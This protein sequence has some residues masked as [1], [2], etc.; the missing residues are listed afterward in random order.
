LQAEA[1]ALGEELARLETERARRR[2]ELVAA[3]RAASASRERL[4]QWLVARYEAG[5]LALLA[6]VFDASGWEEVAY[7][8]ELVARLGEYEAAVFRKARRTMSSHREALK[9]LRRTEA[10]IASREREL[11]RQAA[12]L[13]QAQAEHAALL[14][15]I[16][17][18]AAGVAASIT[19]LERYWFDTLHSLKRA[20]QVLHSLWTKGRLKPDRTAFTFGGLRLEI[21]D[22]SLERQM[23]A[24]GG[25]DMPGVAIRPEGISLRHSG[26]GYELRGRLVCADEGATV[27]FVPQ[28]LL[29]DGTPVQPDV[30]A[31]VAGTPLFTLRL[32]QTGNAAVREIRHETGKLVLLLK[33]P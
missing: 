30:L 33:W 23:R 1:A 5:S 2:E 19:A 3:E 9:N 32:A 11:A 10:R 27:R 17:T 24:A 8:A 18:E 26:A 4:K 29:L 20:F 25:E 12:Q 15:A 22:R 6:I 31:Y 21:S 14:A 7:R 16:R 28:A 13:K